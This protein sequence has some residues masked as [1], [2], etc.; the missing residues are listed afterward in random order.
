MSVGTRSAVSASSAE[1]GVTMMRWSTRSAADSRN[2]MVKKMPGPSTRLKRPR[3]RTTTFS[4][5]CVTC[6]VRSAV[7]R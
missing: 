1:N 6:T 2:G 3:R 4:H 7:I 5:C